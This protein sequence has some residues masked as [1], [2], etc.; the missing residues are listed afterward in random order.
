LPE[1]RTGSWYSICTSTISPGPILATE[2]MNRFGRSCSNR[3]AFCPAR[4]ALS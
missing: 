1:R 3:L 2:L 4:F